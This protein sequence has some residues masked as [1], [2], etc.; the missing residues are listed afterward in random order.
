MSQEG[1]LFSVLTL[2]FFA[3]KVSYMFRLMTLAIISLFTNTKRKYLQLHGWL[4]MSDLTNK[5]LYVIRNMQNTRL[6]K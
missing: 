5:E 3:D 4:H 1:E 2:L 6:Q